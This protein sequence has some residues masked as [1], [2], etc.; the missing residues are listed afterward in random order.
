MVGRDNQ[1][2]ITRV[3]RALGPSHGCERKDL[4]LIRRLIEDF[5]AQSLTHS[6]IVEVLDQNPQLVAINAAV[7]QKKLGE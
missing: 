4:E 3:E 1:V 2:V 5:G 7:E 6:E